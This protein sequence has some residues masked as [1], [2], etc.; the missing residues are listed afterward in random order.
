MEKAHS[1]V[2]GFQLIA[3]STNPEAPSDELASD[4]QTTRSDAAPIRDRRNL[5]KIPPL[6]RPKFLSALAN[7]ALGE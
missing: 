4:L 3:P 6:P 7:F 2:I 5:G 1:R